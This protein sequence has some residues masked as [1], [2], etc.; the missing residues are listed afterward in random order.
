MAI[1]LN[2]N[3]ISSNGFF[4]TRTPK[5]HQVSLITEFQSNHHTLH[6]IP[7]FLPTYFIRRLVHPTY[8]LNQPTIHLT[9]ETHHISWLSCTETY[10]FYDIITLEWNAWR[11]FLVVVMLGSYICIH[12]MYE[13]FAHCK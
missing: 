11:K 5:F 9:F 8:K 1:L 3:L 6:Y 10:K 13:N 7:S 12:A 4:E 2:L